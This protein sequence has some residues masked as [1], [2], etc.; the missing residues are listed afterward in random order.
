MPVSNLESARFSEFWMDRRQLGSY[1]VS[2]EPLS[3]EE[4]SVSVARMVDRSHFR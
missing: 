2:D 3:P 4:S 1:V